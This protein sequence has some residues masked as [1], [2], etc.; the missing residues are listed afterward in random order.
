MR[1]E[2]GAGRPATPD[3]PVPAKGSGWAGLSEASRTAIIV[4]VITG[5]LG[6][7]GTVLGVVLTRGDGK[8]V[9]VVPTPTPSASATPDP[10]PT[11]S[12]T[13][14]PTPDPVV[15][16]EPPPPPPSQSDSPVVPNPYLPAQRTLVLSDSLTKASSRWANDNPASGGCAFRSDGYH[17]TSP[18][19]YHECYGRTSVRDF[20]YEVEFRFPQARVA[21]LFF[22]QSGDG[23][24]YSLYAGH[25]GHV[26]LVRNDGGGAEETL[27]EK[28][29]PEPDADGWHKLAVTGVGG[30]FT[31][32]LDGVKQFSAQDS[33]YRSGPI[34][35][36][37]DGGRPPNGEDANGDTVFRNA[38]VWR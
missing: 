20:T 10:T 16:T 17:V 11:P 19:K 27:G 26:W 37:T 9:P 15:S 29:G 3:G 25:S 24:W 13:S 34:G 8:E 6:I 33:A 30:S 38:R 1:D 12:P 28:Y 7:I 14:S 35:L 23:K 32:F 4:A 21:G 36:I 5:V 31:V 2:P 22:R 18:I